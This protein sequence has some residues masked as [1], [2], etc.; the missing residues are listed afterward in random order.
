MVRPWNHDSRTGSASSNGLSIR[1]STSPCT[2]WLKSVMSVKLATRS[3]KLYM[4]SLSRL[5]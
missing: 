1:S 4:T 2:R 5:P 3:D